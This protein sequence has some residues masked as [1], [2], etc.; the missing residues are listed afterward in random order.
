[1]SPGVNFG[2]PSTGIVDGAGSVSAAAGQAL[3]GYLSDTKGWTAIFLV[4]MG[5]FRAFAKI[6]T[7]H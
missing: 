1:M 6:M 4:I 5:I 7:A 2:T 3:V